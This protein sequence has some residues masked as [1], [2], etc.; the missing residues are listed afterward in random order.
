MRIR[1]S[2]LAA[3]VAAAALAAPSA[4][5]A[6][7]PL[8]DAYL[9]SLPVDNAEFSA[10]V[11]TTAATVQPDLFNP[12]STGQ[13]LG[14]GPPEN[15]VCKG[16][17][18]DKTV[19]YD[20]AP[21]AGG[22]VTIRA[23]GFPTVVAVYEWN[24]QTSQITRMVDCSTTTSTDDLVVSVK[25][26]HN[27]TI[28]VGGAGGAGGP[29]SLRVEYFPDRDGD[30][31]FDALDKC[32]TTP[33]I[34]QFGGCPPE[35]RV[36][37]SI[38]FANTAFGISITRLVVDRVPKGAKVRARCSGCGSQTV[39]AKRFGR[40]SLSKLVGRSVSAGGKVELRITM[41]RRGKAR[42][43]FGA[44]G[45][46]FRWPVKV[47]GLGTRVSRCLHVRTGKIERCK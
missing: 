24:E 28:Q 30:G 36:A 29:L 13:P 18:F 41:G 25:R 33:G 7:A 20:L 34:D 42:Y 26:R 10:T 23:T 37:P 12:S 4:A 35:L 31:S 27:Y 14:G 22:D 38:N 45:A 21:Q 16:T 19:W 46:Y 6:Q 47:G 3:A 9:A 43:R 40:V 17:S 2:L 39:K 15:T 44:T 11:D 8:N 1:P 32:P 5:A